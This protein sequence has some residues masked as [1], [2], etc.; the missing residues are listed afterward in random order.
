K[1]AAYNTEL[2]I[3]PNSIEVL[4]SDNPLP[5]VQVVSPSGVNEETQGELVRI[6]NV[7]ITDL[8]EYNY[9]TFEFVAVS[10]NG[11]EILVRHDNRTGSNYD[12]FLKFY[13]EG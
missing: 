8:K 13:K 4:S 12:D 10:K 7:K 9:G 6:E 5:E 3:Q 1:V 11:E 2:Q